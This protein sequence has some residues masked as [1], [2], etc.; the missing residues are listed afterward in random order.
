[1]IFARRALQRCLD[2]L[3]A[4][5]GHSAVDGLATRLN[6]PGRDRLA[7]MWEVVVLHG[8]S[9]C[10]TVQN[11]VPLPSGRRPDV[12]FNS[13]KLSFTADITTASDESL[14]KNNPYFELS[15]LIE[16]A[17][18]RLGFP[19]GGLDIQVKSTRTKT[20][21]GEK[22]VLRLPKRARLRE[23][24]QTVIVPEMRN[25][26]RDG[27]RAFKITIDDETAGVEVSYD[28]SK[29]PFSG[30]GFAA[31]D[32]PGSKDRNVL[33]KSMRPKAEQLRA[34]EGITG[35][36]AC[37]AACEA[38]FDSAFSPRKIS[39]TAIAKEFL[40]QYSSVDFVLLL[41]IREKQSPL[42]QGNPPV[43]WV[44]HTLVVR[45][46]ASE[47][48][49]LKALFAAAVENF[50]KPVTMPVNAAVRAREKDY[51]FGHHGGF[52]MEKDKVRMSSRELIEILAG[53]RTIEDDGA[54]NVEASRKLPSNT[55]TL[56]HSF[57]RNLTQGRLPTAVRVIHTGD[58]DSDDWIEFEF[59]DPDPAIS[60]F[61]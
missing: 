21:R 48:G 3:R 38:F 27:Y 4:A 53:L 6:Q 23:F 47:E 11:E 13:A 25:R 31:Y 55:N 60:P 54:R 24:V 10:G 51:G 20:A 15:Q 58:D 40:R 9:R 16:A 5:I 19:I 43:R 17:K 56:Q 50:P 30:G 45:D 26:K 7:A 39:A 57:L 52:H 46:D 29:G 44:H 49:F 22:T 34:A 42:W 61:K 18:T 2:D 12:A 28:P 14:D 37:D 1:M 36:V 8:L 33:F 32:V 41:T 35:I 59:G